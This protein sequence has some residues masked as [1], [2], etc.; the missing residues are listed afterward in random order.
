MKRKYLTKTY[1]RDVENYTIKFYFEGEVCVC[2]KNFLK[3][4]SPF[5][6]RH[7][8][9]L[10]D[11][12]FKMVEVMP[13]NENYLMRVYLDSEGEVVERYFDV[14]KQNAIDEVTNAPFYDDLYLDVVQEKHALL[15][16][17]EKE[18]EHA[19]QSGV[20]TKQDYELAHKT[21]NKLIEEIN[22]KTNKYMNLNLEKYLF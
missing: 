11:S 17:D 19:L 7:G 22:N 1:L 9:K 20:I 4:S 21:K 15:V 16:H 13:F 3:V 10:I 12:G 8:Y 5:I 6:S 2:V 14:T 18:L